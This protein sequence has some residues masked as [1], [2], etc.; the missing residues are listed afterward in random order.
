MPFYV[1]GGMYAD[2][3]FVRLV[4][5]EPTTGPFATYEEAAEEWSGRSRATIDIAT[6]RY[7]IVEAD[8]APPAGGGA[9]NFEA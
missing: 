2:T 7:R 8:V 5:P 1:V 9:A 4:R 6:T 3:T